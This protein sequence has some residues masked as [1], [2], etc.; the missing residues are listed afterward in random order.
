MH[1]AER[2]NESPTGAGWHGPRWLWAVW[3][4]YLVVWTAAL[5]RPEPARVNTEVLP[6]PAQFPVAKALHVGSYA[7]L[8]A[9]A[10]WLPVRPGRRWPLFALLSLHAFGTE[11]LQR[12]VE[13]RTSS[14]SDVAID[15]VGLAVGLLAAWFG[16]SLDCTDLRALRRQATEAGSLVGTCGRYC[17]G[18]RQVQANS[19]SPAPTSRTLE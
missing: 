3:V 12:F 10:C 1:E 16:R 11:F 17:A 2:K 7:L 8:A 5:L 14:L 6:E 15:H 13:L 4:L 9:L 18:R 19:A